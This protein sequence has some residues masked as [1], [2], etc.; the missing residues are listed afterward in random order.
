MACAIQPAFLPRD[1]RHHA[2][3]EIHCLRPSTR[4]CR[5]VQMRTVMQAASLPS[6]SPVSAAVYYSEP[7]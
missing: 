4:G 5:V 7:L 6:R 3:Q 1:V 2:G